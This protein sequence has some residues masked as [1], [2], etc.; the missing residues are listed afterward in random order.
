[1]VEEISITIISDSPK[2]PQFYVASA[3]SHA[4]EDIT[5]SQLEVPALTSSG[6][7]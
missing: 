6:G 3:I 4:Q 5:E 7:L 2:I 1:M